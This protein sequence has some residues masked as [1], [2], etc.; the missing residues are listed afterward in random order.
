MLRDA[1]T[2][3]RGGDRPNTGAVTVCAMEPMRSVPFRIVAMVGMDDDS[4]PRPSRPAAWDPFATAKPQEHDRRSLDRHLF[5]ESLLCARDA[6]LIYGRG[7]EP[8]RGEDVPLSVVVEEFADLLAG[9][10]GVEKPRDLL[11]IHPLQPWSLKAFEDATRR[12][13]DPTWAE[14]ALAQQGERRLSGLAA[15]PADAEWPP[16]TEPPTTLTAWEL[17]RALENAPQAFLEKTL[18]LSM[19]DKDKAPEDREPIELDTLEAWKIRD[20]LLDIVRESADD[21]DVGPLLQ[22]QQGLGAIPFEAGGAAV[23]Q[24]ELAAAQDIADRAAAIE[25][26][27]ILAAPYQTGVNAEG[28]ASLMLTASLTDIRLGLDGRHTHVWT[29]AGAKPKGPQLLEVFI[30]ML[31][32]VAAGAPV[33]DAVIVSRDAVTTL[34]APSSDAAHIV[35]SE[36]VLLWWQIR[37]RPIAL[38]AHF[39]HEIAAYAADHP[40][41][42]PEAVVLANTETWFERDDGKGAMDGRAARLLFGALTDRDLEARAAEFLEL[43]TRVWRPL[44][45]ALGKVQ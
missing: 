15:T 8:A 16:E 34:E 24:D 40:D 14:A 42:T 41:E 23:L 39:S 29:L 5:L 37:R 26:E 6:L 18:G 10:L 12:P 20:A 27:R 21:V 44:L 11:R 1:F 43:A 9:A 3:P 31:V 30:S 36:M 4:F 33:R 19:R 28:S 17:A 45:I 2:V 38:V 32:A 25:G 35:L 7:F 13:F 22:R